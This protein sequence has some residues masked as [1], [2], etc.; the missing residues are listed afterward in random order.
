MKSATQKAVIFATAIGLLAGSLA[1]SAGQTYYRWKD[2]EGNSYHSD[3]PPPKGTE[4]E[5]VSTKSYDIRRVEGDEGAVPLDTSPE[6]GNEFETFPKE[7]VKPNKS[8]ELCARAQQNLSTLQDG[9][10]IRLRNDKGEFHYLSEE[11][12]ADQI[13]RAKA[14]IEQNC[15]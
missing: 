1:V 2:D 7:E 10:R 4:Y 14:V 15:E 3:R 13:A 11:E 5:V 9:G 12:K 6:P 8:P